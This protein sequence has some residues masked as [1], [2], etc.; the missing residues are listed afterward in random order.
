MVSAVAALVDAINANAGMS[1]RSVGG[2]SRRSV[3]VMECWSADVVLGG[4]IGEDGNAYH[5]SR[6]WTSVQR[7][8]CLQRSNTPPLQCSITPPLR[9]SAAPRTSGSSSLPVHQFLFHVTKTLLQRIERIAGREILFHNEPL[10]TD[11]VRF[12][13]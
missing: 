4:F 11:L 9:Y 6:L 7:R 12:G 8:Q 5:V 2:M 13:D 3:G 1:K 10:A